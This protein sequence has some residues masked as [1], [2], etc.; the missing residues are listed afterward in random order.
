MNYDYWPPEIRFQHALRDFNR[1][2][3]EKKDAVQSCTAEVVKICNAALNGTNIRHTPIISR[4]KSWDSAKGSIMRRQQER[5]LW[6]QTYSQVTKAEPFWADYCRIRELDQRE[7]RPFQSAEEMLQGLHDIGG[8]RISL[9][10]PGDITSGSFMSSKIA[11]EFYDLRQENPNALQRI[12]ED[13]VVEIQVGTLVMHMWSE[14]EHDLIYKPLDLQGDEVS[15]DEKRTLDLINGIVMMGET[16]LQQLE[17]STTRRLAQRSRD[18]GALA[19]SH[20]ELVLWIESWYRDNRKPLAQGEWEHQDKLLSI[21]RAT[22]DHKHE[23]LEN[24]LERLISDEIPS[25]RDLPEMIIE[26]LCTH[27]GQPR[28][29]WNRR[30]KRDQAITDARF[31]G[32][33]LIQ[34]TKLA[35]YL[36]VGEQFIN[37][38]GIDLALPQFCDF[39]DLMNPCPPYPIDAT[40]ATQ[41]SEYCQQIIAHNKNR[42]FL[43]KASASLPQTG[44]II[45]NKLQK[46][47]IPVRIPGLLSKLFNT[48][49]ARMMMK[50]ITHMI[51]FTEFYIFQ[52]YLIN[53]DDLNDDKVWDRTSSDWRASPPIEQQVFIVRWPQLSVSRRRDG[54]VGRGRRWMIDTLKEDDDA[55]DWRFFEREL[56]SVSNLSDSEEESSDVPGTAKLACRFFP[57]EQRDKVREACEAFDTARRQRSVED[58]ICYDVDTLTHGPTHIRRLR[59]MPPFT[60]GGM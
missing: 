1:L 27:L 36:G 46:K 39:L 54:G 5:L 30:N 59:K 13:I 14:I 34:S 57:K 48:G 10:F 4:I 21:L 56:V 23:N 3:L 12:W 40:H 2:F 44:C 26:A 58:R 49:E 33:R 32:T 52:R 51:K 19:S 53:Y 55:M 41:I 50:D 11:S 60:Y 29:K 35:I 25:R 47:A 45:S 31:W 43:E 20:Y 16:A 8:V 22:G 17:I 28:P 15:D 7:T 42:G 37:T 38:S 9:Y 24:L 6:Q 18:K